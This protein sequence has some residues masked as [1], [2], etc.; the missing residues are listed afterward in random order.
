M[1][2]IS[3]KN[4]F[5]LLFF[6]VL[7][8]CT[9]DRQNEAK[10]GIY[11]NI[12]DRS[13]YSD[14]DIRNTDVGYQLKPLG[15]SNC[16]LFLENDEKHLLNLTFYDKDGDLLKRTS[17]EDKIG[18]SLYCKF[19]IRSGKIHGKLSIYKIVRESSFPSIVLMHGDDVTFRTYVENFVLQEETMYY[20]GIR[21]GAYRK[22]EEGHLIEIGKYEYGN[23]VGAF[24]S[25]YYNGKTSLIEHYS[26][27]QLDGERIEYHNGK[28]KRIE[29]YNSDEMISSQLFI[30]SGKLIED[31][32][33]RDKKVF[34]RAYDESSQSF[35]SYTLEDNEDKIVGDTYILFDDDGE[36][37]G[38][39]DFSEIRDRKFTVS[40]SKYMCTFQLPKGNEATITYI[41]TASDGTT[42]HYDKTQ[43]V[44]H[45]KG[46]KLLGVYNNSTQVVNGEFDFT[47]YANCRI[48]LT[49]S[50]KDMFRMYLENNSIKLR[51]VNEF[52]LDLNSS[53]NGK[54]R[55]L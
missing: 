6:L 34:V 50:Y 21:H 13:D 10:N 44:R 54:F 15:N 45:F 22:F 52:L 40:H 24:K 23:K 33:M 5:K 11:I 12:K 53:Y 1:E 26:G 27:G 55:G 41:I 3:G 46:K 49:D 48:V 35:K 9:G 51:G 18:D 28:L 30:Y 47:Q 36:L 7:S 42:Y 38:K 20:Q 29:K 32:Q 8:S 19:P 25:L 14:G 17:Y 43:I 37:I 4:F 39:M 31:R 2:L 16:Y